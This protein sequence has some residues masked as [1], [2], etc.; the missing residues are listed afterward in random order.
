M[1]KIG[2]A[3]ECNFTMVTVQPCSLQFYKNALVS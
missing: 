2:R 3:V 1:K